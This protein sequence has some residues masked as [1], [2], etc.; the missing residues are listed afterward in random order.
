VNY[1]CL[2]SVMQ[3]IASIPCLPLKLM[4]SWPV[5][6]WKGLGMRLGICSIGESQGNFTEHTAILFFR[7]VNKKQFLLI[8]DNDWRSKRRV[9][10][11]GQKL[12]FNLKETFL[13]YTFI[14]CEKQFK[15][16]Y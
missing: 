5:Y 14:W 3:I 8:K 6:H 12:K 13:E 15:Q 9:Q 1:Q 7:F 16:G 11:Y 2:L 10:I 4:K